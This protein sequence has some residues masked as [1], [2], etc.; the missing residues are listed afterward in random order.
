MKDH[1]P[2]EGCRENLLYSMSCEWHF[3]SRRQF[4][5]R[6][7]QH[8]GLAEVVTNIY[9]CQYYFLIWNFATTSEMCHNKVSG[10]RLTW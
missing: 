1:R 7:A 10:G 4:A 2:F 9:F 3:G 5:G 8:A 6:G